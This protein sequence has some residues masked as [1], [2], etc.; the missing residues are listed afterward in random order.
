MMV[1][2]NK[3]LLTSMEKM[4]VNKANPANHLHLN[5]YDSIIKTVEH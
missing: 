5:L 1:H 4:L 2:G 3:S